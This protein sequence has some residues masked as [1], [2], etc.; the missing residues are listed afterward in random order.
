MAMII[1]NEFRTGLTVMVDDRIMQ[2]VEYHRVQPGKGGAFMR[3]KLRDLERGGV[4][5]RMFRGEEKVEVAFLEGKKQQYLYREGTDRVFMDMESFEQA[6]V[7]EEE[8]GEQAQFLQEGAEVIFRVHAG[9]RI[10]IEVPD[11]VD[12][13]VVRTDPGFRGDTATS[14]SKPAEL[15]TGAVVNVPLFIETGDV[16]RVDTRTGQ[17]VERV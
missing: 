11:F 17:Y 8:L 13:K 2:V 10:A 7:P 12:A 9:R 3:T 16:I 5:T 14:P 1:A 4:I 6:P 15:E